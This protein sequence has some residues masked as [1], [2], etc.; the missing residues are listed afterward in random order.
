M[1]TPDSKSATDLAA[2]LDVSVGTIYGCK[3]KM[4]IN[5][6]TVSGSADH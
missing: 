2:E 6:I 3:A 5:R 4:N 1:H